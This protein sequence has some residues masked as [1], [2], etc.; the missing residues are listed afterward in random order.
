MEGRDRTPLSKLEVEDDAKVANILLASSLDIE[1]GSQT[2]NSNLGWR[3]QTDTLFSTIVEGNELSPGIGVDEQSRRR[4][5][6]NSDLFCV[7]ALFDVAESVEGN[8]P[9]TLDGLEETAAGLR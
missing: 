1:S 6:Q 5:R 7:G 9:Q 2:P 4:L 3:Q 8:G